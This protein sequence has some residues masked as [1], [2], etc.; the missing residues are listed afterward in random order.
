MQVILL[1]VLSLMSFWLYSAARVDPG[2]WLISQECQS[3]ALQ[4]SGIFIFTCV[5]GI[6]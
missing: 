5:S 6:L 3:M 2:L 4:Q 1:Q